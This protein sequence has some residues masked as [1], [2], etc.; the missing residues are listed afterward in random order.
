MNPE[1]L[2]AILQRISERQFEFQLFTEG[3][4]DF[5]LKHPDLSLATSPPIHSVKWRMKSSSHLEEKLL[6]KDTPERPITPDNV[7]REI[8]DLGG[9]RVL[10]LHQEQLRPIDAAIRKRVAD[11]EWS[12]DEEP[13]AYTWDPEAVGFMKELGLRVDQKESFYTSVHYVVRPRQTADAA[14]EI[15]VRT[16]FEEIWGEI[17]HTL[18]YPKP[19]A[20]VA[21][22]EQILVLAKLV[23]AGSRLV[24]ALLRTHAAA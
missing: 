5:F 2:S 23:G 4:R 21:C 15:Q 24:D 6:R 10:H 8:T 18:N 19:T 1:T 12:F 20:V 16:L 3:V 9:V 14:C 17:D 22:K 11:G 13:K 7:F